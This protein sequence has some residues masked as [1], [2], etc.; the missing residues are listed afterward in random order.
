MVSATI[1]FIPVL[2]S[3][4]GKVRDAQGSRGASLRKPKHVAGFANTL[5]RKTFS[6]AANLADAIQSRCYRDKNHTHFVDLRLKSGDVIAMLAI[7]F[8]LGALWT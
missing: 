8:L 7:I 4:A 6:R 3:E 1:R 5:I 2:L